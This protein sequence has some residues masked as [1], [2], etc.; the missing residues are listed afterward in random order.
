MPHVKIR[1]ELCYRCKTFK[2]LC[3]LPTCPVKERLKV[4]ARTFAIVS[5]NKRVY[6]ASPPSGVVGEHAYPNVPTMVNVPPD[7]VS[8]RAREFENPPEWWMRGLSL[9]DIVKIRSSMV[10]I[11]D[12]YNVRDVEKL[13]EREIAL[14]QV[15]SR[16]VDLEVNVEK[17]IDRSILL[18]LKLLPL[19]I[20][21]RGEVKVSSNPRIDRVVEK[22]IYDQ[23]LKARDA[24]LY[25]YEHGVDVYT[26][27]R[28][29]SF[30]LLGT[31]RF[32]KLVPTRWAITAVDRILTEHLRA[33]VRKL[34]VLNRY[35]VYQF[36][37]LNNKFTVVLLPENLRV[38]W[39]E[40]W[41]SRSGFCDR[42][43]LS[44][45]IEEDLKGNVETMDGGF[46]AAR[47]GLLEAMFKH[48]FQARAIIVR[49]ILPEY[50]IGV[51]NWHIREDMRHILD[52][53]PVVCTDDPREVI[54]TVRKILHPDVV[55]EVERI[56]MKNLKQAKLI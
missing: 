29:F 1:P 49:E 50:Y 30:G 18:D 38:Y 24:V 36:S 37:Y 26:I 23:D 52:T 44:V 56:I 17:I 8:E 43:V 45:E 33:R 13:I 5:V 55:Q 7:V 22:V 6:G 34:P 14:T 39:I 20:R 2:H 46:E 54:E 11:V 19:S 12:R 47:M 4:V 41:Y 21:V 48:G 10:S 32:R 3:G 28:A 27:Q 35:Y 42:P 25:L 31:R 53:R 16:P 9:D 15:A 51:G 40:F